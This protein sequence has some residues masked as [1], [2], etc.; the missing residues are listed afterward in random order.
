MARL[1]RTIGRL[2]G[3]AVRS[4]A[5]DKALAKTA[6]FLHTEIKLADIKLK[7]GVLRKKRQ[8]H[9][10]LLGKTVYNLH[11]NEIEPFND[12]HTQTISRVLREI[13]M[14]IE[15]T[16]EQLEIKKRQEQERKNRSNPSNKSE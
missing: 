10:K 15:Q 8:N 13:D 12:T 11:T 14:E 16:D 2:A 7:L 9:L 6:D 5:F 1:F 3:Y 4:Q